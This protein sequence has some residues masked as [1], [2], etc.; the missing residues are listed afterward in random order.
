MGRPAPARLHELLDAIYAQVDGDELV[1]GLAV[2]SVADG[3]RIISRSVNRRP[4]TLGWGAVETLLSTG[5]EAG[6]AFDEA[7]RRY[8]ID[9]TVRDGPT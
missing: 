9:A 7:L 3:G 8:T 1:A 2:T 4:E 6:P 5:P